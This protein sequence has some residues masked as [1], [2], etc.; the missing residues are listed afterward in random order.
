[1]ILVTNTCEYEL[2]KTPVYI[3]EKNYTLTT[4]HIVRTRIERLFEGLMKGIVPMVKCRNGHYIFLKSKC[5][6][7]VPS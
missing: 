4:Q 1:M 6:G 3:S 2:R 5:V 7:V